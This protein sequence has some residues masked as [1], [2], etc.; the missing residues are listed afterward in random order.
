MSTLL[1]LMGHYSQLNMFYF[2][3]SISIRKKIKFLMRHVVQSYDSFYVSD[4][5]IGEY[6]NDLWMR[7][8]FLI[9][10]LLVNNINFFIELL[11]ICC[12]I[13]F[14]MDLFTI[15]LYHGG[16]FLE[17]LGFWSCIRG[18]LGYLDI[19]SLMSFCIMSLKKMYG[20]A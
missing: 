13:S 15:N 4:H 12:N 20:K 9:S 7:I 5:I 8:I 16:K 1:I 18:I 14:S 17:K 2:T 6:F 19:Y 10:C 11:I 3:F